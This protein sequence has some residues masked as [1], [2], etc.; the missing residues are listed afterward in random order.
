M[1]DMD[2]LM[3]KIAQRTLTPAQVRESMAELL[4]KTEPLVLP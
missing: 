1:R 3:A 4:E 2:Y